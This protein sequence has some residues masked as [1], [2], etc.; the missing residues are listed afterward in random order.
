[1]AQPLRGTTQHPPSLQVSRAGRISHVGMAALPG[2]LL[3]ALAFAQPLQPGV[4]ENARLSQAVNLAT[5]GDLSSSGFAGC[6]HDT[7]VGLD[8]R[9]Y[10]NKLPGPSLVGAG[11][12][13]LWH[14]W[15]P[16]EVASEP[17]AAAPFQIIRESLRLLLVA[18]INLAPMMVGCGMLLKALE[19]EKVSR[20]GQ[21]IFASIFLFGN[22]AA[23][24]SSILMGHAAAGGLFAMLLG[25]IIQGRA[26]AS[27]FL[28]GMLC[29]F[30]PAGFFIFPSILGFFLSEGST[31]RVK[32]L[33]DISKGASVPLFVLGGYNLL[34][35]GVPWRSIITDNATM[36]RQP[37]LLFGLFSTL[38]SPAVLDAL[39]FGWQR[40][41]L[42]SNPW[43]L[44]LVFFLFPSIMGR[45]R[46][47]CSSLCR[48]AILCGVLIVILVLL[49]SA[50]NGWHG[51]LSPGPRYIS[52]VLPASA[53]IPTLVFEYGFPPFR[54][55]VL[56]TTAMAIFLN[57][58]LFQV[59]VLVPFVNLWD[60]GLSHATALGTLVRILGIVLVCGAYYCCQPDAGSLDSSRP[61]S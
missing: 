43:T 32:S 58:L 56:T 9:S 28:G 15:S 25:S 61:P 39:L 16:V 21:I 30:D 4:N 14:L 7:T 46:V 60:Y 34:I 54:V 41:L 44:S 22:T 31:L 29:L 47:R 2:L 37:G 36:F 23:A 57:I 40:G 6:T 8:G 59:G 17:C 10:S 11:V 45:I 20:G 50:F 49:N 27:G 42:I 52:L 53:I 3:A 55:I 24:T 38:P 35:F 33:L 51:G 1:M 19:K 12:I 18:I 5:R 48:P 13:Y 26:V